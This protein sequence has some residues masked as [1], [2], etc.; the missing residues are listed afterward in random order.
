MKEVKLMKND[1]NFNNKYKLGGLV[2]SVLGCN[3]MNAV[4]GTFRGECN[5]D[6]ALITLNTG[7]LCYQQQLSTFIHE[8]VHGLAEEF[9]IELT[10]EQVEGLGKALFQYL[11]DNLEQVVEEFSKLEGDK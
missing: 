2:Y 6:K 3:Y 4:G 9:N 7:E 8:V 5:S 11:R 1:F 10:E